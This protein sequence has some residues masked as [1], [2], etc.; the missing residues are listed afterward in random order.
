[1]IKRAP[2]TRPASGDWE[3]FTAAKGKIATTGME[4]CAGC[5][6]GGMDFVFTKFA[7]RK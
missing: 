7:A 4:S 1:M 6:S 2:G 5:H 3:F